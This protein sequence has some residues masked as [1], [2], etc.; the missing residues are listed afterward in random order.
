MKVVDSTSQAV[1][2]CSVQG[3]VGDTT[4]YWLKDGNRIYDSHNIE[5]MHRGETLVLRSV[6][7]NDSGMY[8]CYAQNHDET[9]QAAAELILG[10]MT[11]E[12]IILP[13]YTIVTLL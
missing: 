8:Q 2:N 10:G 4:I 13:D 5:T 3:G 11:F 7:R 9:A 12:S 6:G 1:F